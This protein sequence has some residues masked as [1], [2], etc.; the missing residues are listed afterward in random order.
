MA[1]LL[2]GLPIAAA[3]A[4]T[5]E[6]KADYFPAGC[7]SALVAAATHSLQMNTAAGP[8]TSLT[9][10]S[11]LLQKEQIIV[12]AA[13]CDFPPQLPWHLTP[14]A[15]RTPEISGIRHPLQFRQV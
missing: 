3:A 14:V 9:S 2:A 11:P 1:R 7:W 4:A 5:G 6:H 8:A 13:F 15:F 12:P 10:G